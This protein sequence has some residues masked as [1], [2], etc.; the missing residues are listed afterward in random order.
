MPVGC[1]Q[2][3]DA[4]SELTAVKEAGWDNPLSMYQLALAFAIE[5]CIACPSSA[6]NV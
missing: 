2:R 1:R 5:D 6:P 3:A 4:L